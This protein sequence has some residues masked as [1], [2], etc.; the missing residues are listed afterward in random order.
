[1]LWAVELRREESRRGLQDLV[2]PS[3]LF[4]LSL[5][6]LELRALFGR[7]TVASAAVDLGLGDPG[8]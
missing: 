3:E 4:V 6:P 8:S 5:E 1:M 7:E 2:R